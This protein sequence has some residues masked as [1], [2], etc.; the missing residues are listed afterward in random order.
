M[1]LRGIATN[2][3]RMRGSTNRSH[4]V[5][6]QR[7]E[8]GCLNLYGSAVLLFSNVRLHEWELH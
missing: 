6:P 7:G 8:G 3:G 4:L 5:E 2:G 1:G